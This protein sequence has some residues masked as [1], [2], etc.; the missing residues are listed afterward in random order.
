[1]MYAGSKLGLVKDSGFTKVSANFKA[2]KASHLSLA[3]YSFPVTT[4]T[5]FGVTT[6]SAV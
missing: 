2:F 5:L 1:M 4:Y 3:L 6:A